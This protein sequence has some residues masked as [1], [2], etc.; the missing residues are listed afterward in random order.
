MT[1][2]SLMQLKREAKAAAR[3]LQRRGE[4][5]YMLGVMDFGEGRPSLRIAAGKRAA[6]AALRSMT[7]G[8]VLA[9]LIKE[10]LKNPPTTNYSGQSIP[11][12]VSFSEASLIVSGQYPMLSEAYLAEI[13]SGQEETA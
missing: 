8:E 4:E 6:E 5:A 12:V 13:R 7:V 1:P 9:E 10:T 3:I 11:G 2:E